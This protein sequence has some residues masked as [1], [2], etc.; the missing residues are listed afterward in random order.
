[1]ERQIA[2]NLLSISEPAKPLL[3]TPINILHAKTHDSFLGVHSDA[4]MIVI[5]LIVILVIV[6]KLKP[7]EN[8]IKKKNVKDVKDSFEDIDRRPRSTFKDKFVKS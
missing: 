3:V 1:M 4:L 2:E 5:G 8:K 6:D 7:V